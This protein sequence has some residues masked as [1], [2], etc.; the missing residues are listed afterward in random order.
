[1]T[2]PLRVPIMSFWL[3]VALFIV[4]PV[5]KASWV[6]ATAQVGVVG[7]ASSAAES[8]RL[9]IGLIVS[10]G[11]AP[12]KS[13]AVLRTMGSVWALM[14]GSSLVVRSVAVACAVAWASAGVLQAGAGVPVAVGEAPAVRAASGSPPAGWGSSGWRASSRATAAL[15]APPWSASTASASRAPASGGAETGP[16]ARAGSSAVSRA[17]SQTASREP[18]GG[19][20]RLTL[21]S[22]AARA[23]APRRSRP[24]SRPGR[25]RGPCSPRARA[26]R[27]R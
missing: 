9:V 23:R 25:R 19:R 16:G 13:S 6:A 18:R 12:V 2:V 8:E 17:R 15:P 14:N 20:R 26:S 27:R 5:K 1:M 10:R 4:T 11:V 22:P 21:R 24:A 7:L 3:N